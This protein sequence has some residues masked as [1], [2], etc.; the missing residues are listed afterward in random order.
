M[1]NTTGLLY[2]SP[3]LVP[4]PGNRRLLDRKHTLGAL[5]FRHSVTQL[6]PPTPSSSRDTTQAEASRGP[7]SDPPRIAAMSDT[8]P[9]P[10]S[11]DVVVLRNEEF[12]LPV[13]P[14]P[15]LLPT[16][17]GKWWGHGT[18]LFTSHVHTSPAIGGTSYDGSTCPPASTG[19]FEKISLPNLSM[20]ILLWLTPPRLRLLLQRLV[21]GAVEMA[22]LHEEVTRAQVATMMAR[23]C[24]VQVEGMARERAALLATTRGEVVEATQ[25]VSTSGD[26][27]ATIRQ[28]K[29]A[30]E[31]I[32]LSLEA[33]VSMAH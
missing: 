30:A 22:E 17:W 18:G 12:G 24:A 10:G 8:P 13:F 4:E 27:L 31:V 6:E 29:D 33:E 5:S 14:R 16:D 19:K 32:I 15:P 11:S 20:F 23:A 2:C 21:Q 1:C 28:A 26:E 7:N 3:L 25:R 9:A